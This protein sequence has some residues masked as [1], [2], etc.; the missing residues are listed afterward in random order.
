MNKFISEKIK[1]IPTSVIGELQELCA[2]E[3]GI[4]P[5]SIG[6]PDFDTPWHIREEAIY[7]L[8]NN[9][10]HYTVSSGLLNLRKEIVNYLKRRFDLD[11]GIDE[12]VVTLG[13]SEAL[14]IAL[15]CIINQGDEVIVL[16][17]AYVAYE[18]LITMSGGIIKNIDLKEENDFK[19]T[20]KEL[21]SAI[22]PKTKVL[23]INFPNNPTGA[24]MTKKDLDELVPI[25]KENN[26]MVFSDE[27]YA[28]LSYDDKHYSVAKYKEI[29]DQVLLISGFSKAFAMTGWRLG[30]MC[31]NKD[32]IDVIRS[33]RDYSIMGP[34][35]FV[36]YGGIEAIKGSDHDIEKMKLEFERRRNY[37]VNRLN[38]MG[39]K[40][41]KPKGAFY[42]FPNVSKTGLNG[43][44]FSIKLVKEKKVAVV[45]GTAF[46]KN[47][48]DNIRISYASKIEDLK[49]ALNRIEEF[50][51][52][53][54]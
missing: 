5:L 9:K 49:E 3:E 26:I 13:A 35:T 48:I 45:P 1:Y 39:L 40:C 21:L 32:I 37:V 43:Y 28:E 24:I 46:G 25:I 44:D 2:S 17:P 36:Q 7:A 22:T 8:K 52:D 23:L 54:K 53:L 11:Y 27:I 12:T 31:G 4:I 29:K 33:V 38:E 19:L 10:T 18:P 6:E 47:N 42:C 15:R 50:I 16:K 41:A 14:D 51:N 34:T 20:S 30:Y